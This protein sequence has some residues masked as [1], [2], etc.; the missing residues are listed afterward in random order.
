MSI[1]GIGALTFLS[2]HLFAKKDMKGLF[3]STLNQLKPTIKTPLRGKTVSVETALNSR[4]T[5]D[6][7]GNS[8]NFHWGI[9]DRSKKISN[10]QVQEIVSLAKIPRFTDLKVQ[11]KAERNTLTFIVQNKEPEFLKESMM[12][13]SGMQQ[14]AV[15][16]VCASQGLGMVFRNLGENGKSVSDNEYGTIKIKLGPM[17]PAYDGTFWSNLPPA[18]ENPW[19]TGNLLDP[20]RDGDKP[21]ISTLSHLKIANKGSSETSEESISQLLWAARGRT[22]HLYKSKP[23]GMTIPTWAGKQDISSVY[24]ISDS[25]MLKYM[26]WHNNRPTHALLALNKI[27]SPLYER[28]LRSFSASRGLII[29]GKNEAS[30]RAFWEVGYQ[31]QNLLLQAKSLDISYHAL[32]L[33]EIQ[34]KTIVSTG[35]KDPVAI[36][37]I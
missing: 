35:I 7:D 14:Q 10:K 8:L 17:K 34:K 16:L 9:F 22:P 11:I 5:S 27:E 3:R 29:I 18:G 21:L 2:F 6:Y 28:L 24:L 32:L 20:N 19:V 13:E 31:L 25:Q 36:L 26:N 12:V 15:G 23:W 33:H 37:A 30:G 4:C 1:G